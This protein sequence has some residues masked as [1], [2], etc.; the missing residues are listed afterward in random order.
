MMSPLGGN[1]LKYN[2]FLIVVP[3]MRVCCSLS[4]SP[5]P[6]RGHLYQVSLQ[7]VAGGEDDG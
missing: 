1:F 6:L 2:V 7:A 5:S 3:V 4:L